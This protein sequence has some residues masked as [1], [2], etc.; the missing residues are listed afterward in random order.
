MAPHQYGVDDV[1]ADHL[2][3][4][5]GCDPANPCYSE[6][7]AVAESALAEDRAK[8]VDPALLEWINSETWAELPQL[9]GKELVEL[10]QRYVAGP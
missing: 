3:Q 8:A 9:T 2:A 4:A 1:D 7:L 10:C 5:R 6:C